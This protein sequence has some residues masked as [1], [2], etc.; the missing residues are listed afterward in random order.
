MLFFDCLDCALD[1]ILVAIV[2]D[3]EGT[4][5]LAIGAL[6]NGCCAIEPY[7]LLGGLNLGAKRPRTGVDTARYLGLGCGIWLEKLTPE[8]SMPRN[9]WRRFGVPGIRYAAGCAGGLCDAVQEGKPGG[10]GGRS[11]GPRTGIFAS[12]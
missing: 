4:A 7:A 2:L 1:E 10:V 5:T 8:G 12:A 6:L 3:R 11:K 9:L